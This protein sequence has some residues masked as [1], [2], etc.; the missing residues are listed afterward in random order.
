[1]TNR[2]LTLYFISTSL[3]LFLSAC[4]SGDESSNPPPPQTP[5]PVVL[6]VKTGVAAFGGFLIE[7][8]EYSSGQVLS[9][10]TNEEGEFEFHENDVITFDLGHYSFSFDS[11]LIDGSSVSAYQ[12][13]PN[14]PLSSTNLV[15]IL[16]ALDSDKSTLHNIEISDTSEIPTN[17]DLSLE[18]SAFSAQFSESF[19]LLL[20]SYAQAKLQADCWLDQRCDLN[21]LISLVDQQE[22]SALEIDKVGKQVNE[23]SVA[24][25]QA[26]INFNS[27]VYL[28]ANHTSV[29]MIKARQLEAIASMELLVSYADK[30]IVS[31][32]VASK[33]LYAFRQN[34]LITDGLDV[35][36]KN[37]SL[38]MSAISSY[39]TKMKEYGEDA[40][41]QLHQDL[42]YLSGSQETA[43]QWFQTA[44]DTAILVKEASGLSVAVL[45]TIYSAGT[46]TSVAVAEAGWAST[47]TMVV[48]GFSKLDG[49]V[50]G[51][52]A[53]IKTTKAGANLFLGHG[54]TLAKSL[55]DTP[56]V[57][58]ITRADEIISVVSIFD[59]TNNRA[60]AV[61]S[62][63]YIAGQTTNLFYNNIIEFGD[64]ALKIT[65]IPQKM[66][67]AIVPFQATRTGIINRAQ[68]TSQALVD[69]GRVA[70]NDFDAGLNEIFKYIQ[71][72]GVH[73]DVVEKYPDF[74][75]AKS[76]A[77]GLSKNALLPG[78]Y[79]DHT[80]KEQVYIDVIDEEIVT[81]IVETLPIEDVTNGFE[82]AADKNKW[83]DMGTPLDI[84]F[85][86]TESLVP[87]K[88]AVDSPN[89]GCV[90]YDDND[91]RD[92]N[93]TG[94]HYKFQDLGAERIVKTVLFYEESN[95]IKKIIYSSASSN[96]NLNI[97]NYS[98]EQE[99]YNSTGQIE[100]D[101]Y[102]EGKNNNDITI[103]LKN[104]FINENFEGGYIGKIQTW[105]WNGK[106][107]YDIDRYAN[108]Q[109]TYLT[110]EWELAQS[111]ILT[112][113]SIFSGVVK[114]DLPKR[115]DDIQATLIMNDMISFHGRIYKRY[116]DTRTD[117][118]YLSAFTHSA[119]ET[120]NDVW[121]KSGI[122]YNYSMNGDLESSCIFRANGEFVSFVS[123]DPSVT[124]KPSYCN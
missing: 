54:S 51:A 41:F 66:F 40:T 84:V 120:I 47:S 53:L 21:E 89:H 83:N 86:D 8:L 124:T 108:G 68:S 46:L 33:K 109:I 24:L 56:L 76:E 123:F 9:G 17:L 48:N 72:N 64:L 58:T 31:S 119:R 75:E 55:T 79:I 70:Y 36:L 60:D 80:T 104:I 97:S 1:M 118:F 32:N 28:D 74:I 111:E 65:E 92:E 62:I 2:I 90:N 38:G 13:F 59:P 16:M 15:R 112:K 96:T 110:W 25:I 61:S 6:T 77:I 3:G 10:Q 26:I 102:F 39:Y 69:A 14:D 85:A 94:C 73:Q 11:S 20:P 88:N 81:A 45:G 30:G 107:L 98:V 5:P 106:P 95:L 117:I 12:L 122:N 50:S 27:Y 43:N 18:H 67:E 101:Y 100:N 37:S 7:N 4:G 78:N 99:N 57:N 121:H 115:M 49:I 22:I 113:K 87:Y 63:Q 35:I 34:D 42:A 44:E 103:D 29:E 52:S 71:S 105:A 114:S 93:G 116:V 23:F 82:E 91:G 19:Q